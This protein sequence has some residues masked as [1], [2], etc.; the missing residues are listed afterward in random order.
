MGVV[1][2]F[3]LFVVALDLRANGFFILTGL[4]LLLFPVGAW[5]LLKG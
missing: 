5:G 3:L 2:L 1:C 4:P